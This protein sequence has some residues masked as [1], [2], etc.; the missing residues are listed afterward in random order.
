MW[1]KQVYHHQSWSR[2]RTLK[3]SFY[4]VLI[5]YC[6]SFSVDDLTWHNWNS[7]LN[8]SFARS[9]FREIKSEK[10]PVRDERM[11]TLARDKGSRRSVIFLNTYVRAFYL[12]RRLMSW[13]FSDR[14]FCCK[15]N[16][17][18]ALLARCPVNKNYKNK[19]ESQ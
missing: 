4:Y 7:R 11:L 2:H 13:N 18:P 3:A 15:W 6:T 16:S 5:S 1:S 19:M 10:K 8:L 12:F 17:C 14:K 9:Q